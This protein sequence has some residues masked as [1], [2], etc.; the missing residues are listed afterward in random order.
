MICDRRFTQ[1]RIVF[2]QVRLEQLQKQAWMY[3]M[4]TELNRKQISRGRGDGVGGNGLFE[5]AGCFSTVKDIYIF[6]LTRKE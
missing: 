4:Q 6:I 3:G 2:S 5:I 1:L